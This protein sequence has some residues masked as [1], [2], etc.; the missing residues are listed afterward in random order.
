MESQG[1]RDPTKENEIKA[2]EALNGEGNTRSIEITN[3]TGQTNNYDPNKPSDY[4]NYS[5]FSYKDYVGTSY[6]PGSKASLTSLDK[7]NKDYV[8]YSVA[9][10]YTYSSQYRNIVTDKGYGATGVTSTSTYIPRTS[11]Y[12]ENGVTTSIT[13]PL[14][15]STYLTSQ[16]QTGL[17]NNYFPYLLLLRTR[18]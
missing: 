1:T 5:N 4:K 16:A 6:Q 18:A 8:S 15:A 12:A 2:T 17:I 13:K 9:N 3:Q 14:T 7:D 11:Y 10:P